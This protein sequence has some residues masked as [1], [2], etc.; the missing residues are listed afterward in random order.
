MRKLF[1]ALAAP[2]VM[3]AAE[4]LDLRKINNAAPPDRYTAGRVTIVSFGTLDRCGDPPEGM[5][6]DGCIR[7]RGAVVH[8]P[9]PCLHKNEGKFARI[10]CHE[11]GHLNGWNETHNN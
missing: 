4:P 11:L 6:F 8:M 2:V 10:M 7:E 1:V 5:Q 3:S 9:N